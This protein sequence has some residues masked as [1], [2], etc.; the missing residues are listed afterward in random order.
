MQDQTVS[1][2]EKT[3]YGIYFIIW[4]GLLVFTG[5]TVTLAGINLGNLSI[6]A[7]LVIASLK[8]S[9]VLYIFMHLKYESRFIKLIFTLSV[10][11]L[12]IFI[13]LTF[14]DV[15]FR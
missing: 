15:L 10:L 9:M 5:L 2:I 12:G 13:G 4:L 14:T 7:I 6:I 11:A 8:S 1:Q 3:T